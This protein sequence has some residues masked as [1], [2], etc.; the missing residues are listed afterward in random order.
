MMDDMLWSQTQCLAAACRRGLQRKESDNWVAKGWRGGGQWRSL[1]GRETSEYRSMAGG[2]N[3]QQV[4]VGTE[5]ILDRV[6]DLGE[7]FTVRV[8]NKLKQK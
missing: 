4:D 1:Q 2:G 3:T 7:K 8:E 6:E 5:I